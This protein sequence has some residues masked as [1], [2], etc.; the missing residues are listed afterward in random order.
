[1][2]SIGVFAIVALV[3]V[4]GMCTGEPIKTWNGIGS[5]TMSDYPTENFQTT[6]SI[7]G[8]TARVTMYVLE[9]P[10]RETAFTQLAQRYI[11]TT[12]GN[13]FSD[14]LGKEFEG[15]M[16][17][18]VEII[19][20]YENEI[21]V[22]SRKIGDKKVS[23]QKYAPTFGQYDPSKY[24]IETLPLEI[25]E[26][27]QYTPVT[28]P[29]IQPPTQAPTQTPAKPPTPTP[30]QYGT[31]P[32]YE[33]ISSLAPCNCNSDSYMCDDFGSW[34]EAQTC[35]D[36]CQS[37]GKGDIHRLDGDNDGTVCES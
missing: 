2:K 1:M 3:A 31:E 17:T 22:M 5:V 12:L 13:E 30:V 14:T 24:G 18:Y 7:D 9:A 37:Q 4:C 21:L 35:H 20:A 25:V 36:Y 16:V 15:R 11:T 28:A 27:L 6:F 29:P 33:P 26:R 23:F 19:G 32:A 8:S 10:A 34:L